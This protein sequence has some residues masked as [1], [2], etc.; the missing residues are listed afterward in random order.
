VTTPLLV[1][2]RPCLPGGCPRSVLLR[3]AMWL[4]ERANRA[5]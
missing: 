4:R 2:R 1:R 3:P 5:R